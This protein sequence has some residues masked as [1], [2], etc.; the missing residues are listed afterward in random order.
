MIVRTYSF[1]KEW[2][3]PL[4]TA[5]DS[6]QTLLL[7]FGNLH[8]EKH[9]KD[10][11]LELCKKFPNSHIVGC[12]TAGEIKDK[13]FFE[14]SLVVAV[15]KL[16]KSFLESIHK[17]LN[18]NS[19]LKEVGSKIVQDLS[20]KRENL[21]SIIF[22]CDGININGTRLIEGMNE[23]LAPDVTLSGGLAGDGVDFKK[24]QIYHS[25]SILDTGVV[26]VGFYGENIFARGN[27]EGGWDRFGI[28]RKITSSKDNILYTLN[29]EPALKIYKRYLGEFSKNLPAS[30]L[31][32]PLL[33]RREQGDEPKVRT[34]LQI[35]EDTQAM[36]FA[37][38]IPEG[39]FATFMKANIE[40]LIDAAYS[41]TAELEFEPNI[42]ENL[43]CI[44][45]SCVGRQ[46]VL[47]QRTE[48][49]LEAV[50][51]VLPANS[52]QIGFYSYGEVSALSNGKCDLH[53]QTMTVTLIGEL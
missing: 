41:T 37:G 28:D 5:Y 48:E 2:N 12:S 1:Q 50:M 23:K 11:Y 14:K 52:F 35:D 25:N 17:K 8:K 38:D 15:V 40:R 6:P 16:E 10:A 19:N 9:L 3:Q 24:T 45:I 39:G 53:N 43:L 44:S 22:F 33:V 20:N 26:A 51:E 7:C 47:K 31:R 13:E 34:I 49:E 21:K 32:F 46:L 36:I 29:D 30:A 27:Y 4:D 42:P 18:K